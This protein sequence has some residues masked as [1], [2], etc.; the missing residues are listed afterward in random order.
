MDDRKEHFKTAK[1]SPWTYW[2]ERGAQLKYW[3][4][5]KFVNR[6]YAHRHGYR[7]VVGNVSNFQNMSEYRAASWY[8]VQFLKQQLKCC[9][10]WAFFID[11]DSYFR[12]EDHTLSIEDWLKKLTTKD[13]FSPLVKDFGVKMDNQTWF[14]EDPLKLLDPPT[15]K[16]NLIALFP[17]NGDNLRGWCGGH[18]P[19][20]KDFSF[21][22]NPKRCPHFINAGVIL[23]RK[24]PLT[25]QFL[26]S[27]YNTSTSSHFRKRPWE[28]HQ[29]NM[30]ALKY[31]K[32]IALVPMM[33]LTGP[34]GRQLRH[35]WKNSTESKE[36]RNAVLRDAALGLIALLEDR[37]VD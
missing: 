9:C 18:D 23:M 28:Q 5:S 36:K 27:W 13:Y 37:E 32:N 24:S 8:K 7:F 14:P 33:E 31:K 10:Q 35:F 12:M 16:T 11:S 3:T 19:P 29:L 20:G 26:D 15:S 6:A 21:H 2:E 34:E 17:R 4:A 1:E 25:F 30:I 22:E